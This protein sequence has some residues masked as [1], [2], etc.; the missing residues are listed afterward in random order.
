[1]AGMVRKP[2]APGTRFGRLVVIELLDE[3]RKRQRVY[4]CR[5]DCGTVKAVRSDY[6]RKGETT[7]CGCRL[8][9]I[10]IAIADVNRSHGLTPLGKHH[11]LYSTWAGMRQRCLN[12]SNPRYAQYGGRGITVDPRWDNFAAFLVDMGE[13]PGPDYSLDR[14]DNDGPYSPGNCRWA[15]PE[16]Q[17]ANCPP[18]R[19]PARDPTT[20]RWSGPSPS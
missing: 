17:R 11:P 13:K 9:E 12:P 7:S 19:L 8:K 6:L 1:M 4:L 14:R 10:R 18:R 2:I 5:C 20:G 3:R 16:Q 15:T